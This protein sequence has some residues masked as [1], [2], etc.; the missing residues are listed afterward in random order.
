MG[1]GAWWLKSAAWILDLGAPRWAAGLAMLA[2]SVFSALW[3]IREASGGV[4]SPV[5][6]F[7]LAS[8]ATAVAATVTLGAQVLRWPL[9][10]AGVK[11]YVRRYLVGK[12]IG[13]ETV[14]VGAGAGG[15]LAVG[16]VSKALQDLGHPVPLSL[17]VDFEYPAEEPVVGTLLPES[18]RLT[19]EDCLIV[20][21]YVGTGRTLRRLRARLGLANVPV[22]S[23]VVSDG[24]SD[25]EEID[26]AL[27]VGNR[28]ILPWPR[29][30]PH[31]ARKRRPTP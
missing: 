31:S 26:H 10:A 8:V 7:A 18:Y 1:Q 5:V 9:L 17:V 29:T 11:S 24:L 15:A 4:G 30:I 28:S 13:P 25:R 22:F 16:L 6:A 14:L 27:I 21:S 12:V 20:Q 23:L 19:Q 2:F 3:T